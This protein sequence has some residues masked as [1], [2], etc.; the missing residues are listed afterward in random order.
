MHE[1]LVA[2]VR[3]YHLWP[4]TFIHCI[5]ANKNCSSTS[6]VVFVYIIIIFVY[7]FDNNIAC[8]AI[9][10][11]PDILGKTIRNTPRL[12]TFLL[13]LSTH[14]F[15]GGSDSVSLLLSWSSLAESLMVCLSEYFTLLFLGALSAPARLL[16]SINS[17]K[18]L[19]GPYA[20]MWLITIDALLVLE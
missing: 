1:Q 4:P 12:Q 18:G 17:E 2:H 20:D 13:L 11:H 9:F 14:L 16:F 7:D 5:P 10:V 19:R 3:F 6:D 8:L 15:C